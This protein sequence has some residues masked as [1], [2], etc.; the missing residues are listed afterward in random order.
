MGKTHFRSQQ[1][2]FFR[3]CVKSMGR[4]VG[5]K[6][7]TGAG[8][9]ARSETCFTP[10]GSHGGPCTTG[11]GAP[12]GPPKRRQKYFETSLPV[13][14]KC[15][16]ADGANAPHRSH[17]RKWPPTPAAESRGPHENTAR[18][19]LRREARPVSAAEVLQKAP[20]DGAPGVSG[21]AAR[22]EAAAERGS[23]RGPGPRVVTRASG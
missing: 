22:P 7:G 3:K 6:R 11:P 9:E 17:P 14:L 2:N 20:H 18:P 23:D 12:E 4:N 1:V 21:R 13:V 16:S 8:R 15:S 5:P 10:A 19:E